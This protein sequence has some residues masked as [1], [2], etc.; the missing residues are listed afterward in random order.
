MTAWWGCTWFQSIFATGKQS[1]V[2]TVI[3]GG[4]NWVVGKEKNTPSITL[5]VI[6]GS[7]MGKGTLAFVKCHTE[8]T[9]CLKKQSS[10]PPNASVF[11]FQ[12]THCCECPKK[13]SF[14]L[15]PIFSIQAFPSRIKVALC[16]ML[17]LRKQKRIATAGVWAGAMIKDIAGQRNQTA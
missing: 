17:L 6:W 10:I 3:C 5:I 15:S 4:D 16:E 9:I 14:V 1:G 12:W 13:K 7:F 2:S 8:V 11:T